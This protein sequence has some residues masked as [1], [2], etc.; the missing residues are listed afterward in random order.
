MPNGARTGGR[1]ASVLAL[2]LVL[3]ALAPFSGRD[4]VEDRRPP[5]LTEQNFLNPTV[6]VHHSLSPF[7]WT[8]VLRTP[9]SGLPASFPS[10]AFPEET[11]VHCAGRAFAWDACPASPTSPSKRFTSPRS[12]QMPLPRCHLPLRSVLPMASGP[13]L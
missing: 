8:S 6:K 3:R 13:A 5:P 7:P 9:A 1:Q 12:A 10:D 4:V 11:P 2:G